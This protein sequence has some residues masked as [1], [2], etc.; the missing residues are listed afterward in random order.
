M[1]TNIE[2]TIDEF[3]SL[4]NLVS[5]ANPDYIASEGRKR[6]KQ[7]RE[8]AHIKARETEN[9]LAREK[10]QKYMDRTRNPAKKQ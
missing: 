10:S 6:E 3:L 8:D 9:E 4:F 2:Q 1:L 7:R 5:K